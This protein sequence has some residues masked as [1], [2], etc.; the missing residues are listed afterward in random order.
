MPLALHGS[1]MLLEGGPS[2]Y[3]GYHGGGY[4]T[5]LPYFF[6]VTSVHPSLKLDVCTDCTAHKVPTLCGPHPALLLPGEGKRSPGSNG[7]CMRE[8]LEEAETS[9]NQWLSA[10]LSI[11][12]QREARHWRPEIAHLQNIG[13]ISKGHL[14]SY[15]HCN[16][17]QHHRYGHI[18]SVLNYIN[19]S[20]HLLSN[21]LCCG[22]A[23]LPFMT[24]R[25][26]L[27]A[28]C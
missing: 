11:E 26:C 20:A 12:K 2:N 3:G 7:T 17:L 1:T 28:L 14:Y 4:H 10:D 22:K 27:Q 5:A 13:S 25:V 18:L 9:V 21:S 6:F 15:I 19:L 8:V 24:T 23:K 16:S